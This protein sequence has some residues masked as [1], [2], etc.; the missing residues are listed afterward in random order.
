MLL[1]QP[2]LGTAVLDL[3][4]SSHAKADS[5]QERTHMY[6]HLH[7]LWLCKS[8]SGLMYDNTL[9][10]LQLA[11]WLTLRLGKY[12]NIF[13]HEIGIR[14]LYFDEVSFLLYE[15]DGTFRSHNLSLTGTQSV[16]FTVKHE[17]DLCKNKHDSKFLRDSLMGVN[18]RKT[19]ICW[20][21]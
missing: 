10:W 15:K 2:Y 5:F 9:G 4:W 19:T 3:F 1:W 17:H 13:N 8:P 14:N 16:F 11:V 7:M 6:T 20:S 12:S 21:F 18:A